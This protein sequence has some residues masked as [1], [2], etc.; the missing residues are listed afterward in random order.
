MNDLDSIFEAE[1]QRIASEAEASDANP[2][3]QAQRARKRAAEVAREIRA[4]IRDADGV[5]I[6]C[7]DEEFEGEHED[8]E[9]EGEGE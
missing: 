5:L 2:I 8:E 4:G 3:I 9:D 1:A 6:D 7:P